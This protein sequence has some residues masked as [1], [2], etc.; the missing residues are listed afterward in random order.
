MAITTADDTT[1]LV[2]QNMDEPLVATAGPGTV[3]MYLARSPYKDTDSEDGIALVAGSGARTV[4]AVADGVGGQAAGAE[5]ATIA[6]TAI[7]ESVRGIINGTES[8]R[9]AIL[10]GFEQGNLN[11]LE[12]GCGGATTL[13]VLE[14]DGR[15]IR[16][17]HVGDTAVIVMGQR[18]RLKHQTVDHSP[19]G[20]AVEAGWICEKEAIHHE[21][22]HIVS[23]V[24][25]ST[26]MRIDVG[27]GFDLRPHDT[28]VLGSDGLFDNLH[29]AE[30]IEL[31]RKGPLRAAAAALRTAA[32]QRMADPRP[33]EP[34]KPDDLSIA[35]FRLGTRP[36]AGS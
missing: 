21:D 7:I 1:L 33:G 10:N 30:I 8:L 4:I 24:I 35:V 6:L 26:E 36:P 23:N 17:Y 15:A 5:A 20:Y 28:V 2:R 3:A 14:V 25:G 22:R 16:S 18:G 9:P 27:P 13:A 11:V 29:V 32:H 34:S 19:V 12:L 31:A